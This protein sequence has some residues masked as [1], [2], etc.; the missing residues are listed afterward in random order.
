[1]TA[2]RENALNSIMSEFEG[3]KNQTSAIST[4]MTAKREDALNIDACPDSILCLK[5][6]ELWP[7]QPLNSSVNIHQCTN[8]LLVI[9]HSGDM[10]KVHKHNGCS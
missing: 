2:K 3:L 4:E 10:N 6:K 1:M 8:I 5:A 9:F 7:L